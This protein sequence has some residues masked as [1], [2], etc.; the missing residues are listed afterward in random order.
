MQ[1]L[2]NAIV[3]QC[4]ICSKNNPKIQ[5][6]PPLGQ[7]KRGQ[8]PG[9]YW[10]IDFSELPRCNQFKYLLVLVDTF[11]GWP[12]AFPCQTNKAREVVRVLLKDIIPRFG[13]PEGMASDNVPH[14]IAKIVQEVPKKLGGDTAR[15]ADPNWPKGYSIPYGV[16]LSIETGGVGQGVAVAARGLAGRWVGGVSERLRGSELLTGAKPQHPWRPQCSGKV[17]RMNQTLKR[18]I[19][20]LCQET[21]MKWIEV[22]PIALL[23]IRITPRV[24]EGASPFEILY[25]K[26][27]PVNKLTGRSDQMHVSGDQIL[28]EY[29]LSL[30][31]TLSSLH[32]YLNERT[33]V[34][35][36]TPVHTF[37]PGVAVCS[38]PPLPAQAVTIS[39]SHPDS[40]I[41]LM[42]DLED[43]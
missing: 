5:R 8:T 43:E 37:Q 38:P 42:L 32:R 6:R 12:E 35:L 17:E 3:K 1:K 25:G 30:G 13:I 36:D 41:Q 9:E 11:S 14:L 33:P 40:C 19:L 39:G 22:L 31:C 18:Q 7:V 24:R 27:Y 28:T 4:S 23:R 34:P 26:L 29:L 15:T 21:Q 10:Q 16:M 2:A 20:K